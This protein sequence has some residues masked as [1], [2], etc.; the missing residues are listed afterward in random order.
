MS[1]TG[2]A[3]GP[4]PTLAA[5][6]ILF[7]FAIVPPLLF[8]VWI[9][10]TE[11]WRREPWRSVFWLFVWG[12]VF[13]ILIAV[14]LEGLAIR[15]GDLFQQE[16]VA[17]GRALQRNPSLGIILLAVVVAPVMEELAKGLGVYTVRR[18]ILEPEDGLVYGAASGLGFAATENFFYGL[19]A[20]ISAPDIA[21][22]LVSSLVVIGI[23][24]FSSALLHAS[25]AG[26]FGF[27]IARH[28]LRWGSALPYYLMAVAMHG[29]FNF[30]ASFGEIFRGAYGD[31]AEVFGLA[32][33][34]LFA[35]AAI[36][37]IRGTIRHLDRPTRPLY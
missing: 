20:Y 35:I 26:T 23:R 34:V 12:L 31:W 2:A 14:V 7:L 25:A 8:V 24:S 1:S 29:T 22:A 16:Y 33:A 4:Y 6:V 17:L 21:S 30:L 19:V 28:H 32:A 5:L 11:R 27:G 15:A 37:L 18:Q 13:A 36:G 9:R 3:A 10:N